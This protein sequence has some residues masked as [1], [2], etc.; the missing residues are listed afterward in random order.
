VT[1]PE[2]TRVDT[3]DLQLTTW[4]LLKG[5]ASRIVADEDIMA[6]IVHVPTGMQAEGYGRDDNRAIVKAY[7]ALVLAMAAKLPEG[8]S[9]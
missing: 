3:R 1:Q 9:T 6:R 4:Q 2:V 7:E 5:P 8:E